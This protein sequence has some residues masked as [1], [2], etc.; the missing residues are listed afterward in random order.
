MLAL[1][2]LAFRVLFSSCVCV[3][4]TYLSGKSTPKRIV[5][6]IIIEKVGLGVVLSILKEKKSFLATG[7]D[8]SQDCINI[9]QYNA[10]KLGVGNRIKLLK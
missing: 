6:E 7:I 2:P 8:L 1:F 4:L 3:H 5:K 10:N 9:C